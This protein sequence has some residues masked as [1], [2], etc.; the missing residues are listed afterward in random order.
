MEMGSR[1][2]PAL[3]VCFISFKLYSSAILW[4]IIWPFFLSFFFKCTSL[5]LAFLRAFLKGITNITR[6]MCITAD[7]KILRH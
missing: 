7:F 6:K 5:D 3:G 1:Y 4:R 2:F